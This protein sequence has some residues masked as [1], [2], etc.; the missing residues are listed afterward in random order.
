[1]RIR[2]Y[3]PA[4]QVVNNT[5]KD[6]NIEYYETHGCECLRKDENCSFITYLINATPDLI[7][8]YLLDS[9]SESFGE[10]IDTICKPWN[11]YNLIFLPIDI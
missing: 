4:F 3:I 2:N 10:N 7:S 11:K 5:I 8:F 1:M 6:N 9:Y